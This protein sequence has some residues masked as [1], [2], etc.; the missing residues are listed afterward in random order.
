MEHKL[1]LKLERMKMERAIKMARAQGR[2]S[3][4]L[5]G[6]DTESVIS[7]SQ[8]SISQVS[9]PREKSPQPVED[10]EKEPGEGHMTNIE[11]AETR[12]NQLR[13]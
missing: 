8:I 9:V 3:P 4:P 1:R 10:D 13:E 7:A 5:P 12:I 2:P 11:S 6:D